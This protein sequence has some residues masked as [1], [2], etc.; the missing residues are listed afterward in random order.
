MSAPSGRVAVTMPADATS[1]TPPSRRWPS[2]ALAVA[3]G[4]AAF[5]LGYA[6][7]GHIETGT[8]SEST[9]LYEGRQMVD[10]HQ[11]WG[12][13]EYTHYPNGPHYAAAVMIRA[14]L[15][16]DGMR[17]VP[18]GLAAFAFGILTLAWFGWAGTTGQRAFAIAAATVLLLQPA[19]LFWMGG[20]HQHSY[21]YTMVLLLVGT[22]VWAS[23]K[24]TW[25]LFPLGFVAGWIGYDWL[26]GQ[27]VTVLVIRWLVLTRNPGTR[28]ADAA[29]VAMLD[30][31]KF[32][33]G[34]ALAVL[35]HLGQLALY[36][37]SYE[38]ASRDLLGSA[39]ARA[40]VDGASALNPEYGRFIEQ[41]TA[42]LE[43]AYSGRPDLAM[44]FG[45]G[46]DF[47]DPSPLRLSW[48]L[49]HIFFRPLWSHLGLLLLTTAVGLALTIRHAARAPNARRTALVAVLAAAFA[50]SAPLYWVFLMPQHALSHLHMVPRHGLIPFTLLFA[51]PILLFARAGGDPPTTTLDAR[52][53]A[54]SAGLYALWPVLVV[55]SALHTLLALR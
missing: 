8:Q 38:V 42:A 23:A 18:L 47:A 37:D 13:V 46:F 1:D 33:S 31:L 34:V 17:I 27:A 10:G 49:Y 48:V 19:V 41:D 28:L 7:L 25:V 9:T 35:L 54:R 14:G 45:E 53:F 44:A 20:I 2:V 26:P 51:I 4:L 50:L 21:A 6:Q 32:A 29:A 30:T 24:T 52:A 16:E 39:A 11:R 55:A 15:S 5:V 12:I 43:R 40:S 3:F 22:S 36:F